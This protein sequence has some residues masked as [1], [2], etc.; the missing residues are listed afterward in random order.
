MFDNRSI[1]SYIK[2]N[3]TLLELVNKNLV[4]CIM[5]ALL[6]VEDGDNKS[7]VKRILLTDNFNAILLSSLAIT[8][9]YKKC[10]FL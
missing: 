6:R 7:R 3:S 8:C 2:T 5:Y 9:L 10:Y 4:Y 1:Q